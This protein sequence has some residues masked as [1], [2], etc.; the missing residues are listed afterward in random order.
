[1]ILFWLLTILLDPVK[2]NY[3]GNRYNATDWLCKV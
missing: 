2:V 1:M 3:E